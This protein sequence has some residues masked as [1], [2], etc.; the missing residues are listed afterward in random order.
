MR[1]F[2]ILL[3]IR[4]R[5]TAVPGKLLITTDGCVRTL[6]VLGSGMCNIDARILQASCER[7][8]NCADSAT[9]EVTEP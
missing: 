8:T 7:T 6:I 5:R 4:R 9:Y 2:I 1:L 3:N